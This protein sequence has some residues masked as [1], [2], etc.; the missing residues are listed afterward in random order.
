MSLT[1]TPGDWNRAQT[2]TVTGVDDTA[3]DG[4]RPYTIMLTASSAD[5][6]Y[7]GIDLADVRVTNDG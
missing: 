4:D 5:L 2:V 6:S 1:F 7:N 3:A